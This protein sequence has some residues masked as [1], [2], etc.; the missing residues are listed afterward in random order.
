M[1]SFVLKVIACITMFIDHIGYAI[2]GKLSWC[3]YI[4]R[5]AFPIF[6]YQI[7]EGYAHTKSLKKYFL[8]LLVCAIV[9]QIPFMLC[10]SIISR[11][12]GLNIFFTL[13][14]GLLSIFLFEK[15][16]SKLLS[17]PFIALLCAFA[18]ITNM[19]YGYWGVLLI[20]VFYLCKNNK[21]LLTISF[22]ALL[23]VHY[24]PNFIISNF[25]YGYI[26][27]MLCTFASIVP[28]LFYNQKQGRK[29]KY[30]LYVFYPAH[31]LVIYGLH[32]LFFH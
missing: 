5:I 29:I 1:S 23:F 25:Y 12:F 16:P 11:D 26:Y 13:L 27:L 3:N 19:D 9:S 31:L 17:I 18:E 4:G 10:H 28:I 14:L 22:L 21:I 8:R 7:T 6:A 30:F 20:F 15:L 24:V 32:F 2:Y